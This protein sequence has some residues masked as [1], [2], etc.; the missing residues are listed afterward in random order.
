MSSEAFKERVDELFL[1]DSPK[2]VD[3]T[4]SVI[5][6][7]FNLYVIDRDRFVVTQM[8]F[9]FSVSGIIR[10]NPIKIISFALDIVKQIDRTA[11]IVDVIQIMFCISYINRIIFL[12]IRDPKFKNKE[13]RAARE[14]RLE[15]EGYSKGSSIQ[16]DAMIVGCFI[17]KIFFSMQNNFFDPDEFPFN[18]GE[19]VDLVLYADGY[20]Q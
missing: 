7:T 11:I 5:I 16:L 8:S 19:Y 14:Q 17:V 2:F 18:T 15:W 4:T 12:K 13:Q 6:I 20:M 10:P 9:D 3:F 1:R